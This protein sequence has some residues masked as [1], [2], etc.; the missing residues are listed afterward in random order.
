MNL[1]IAL[2]ALAIAAC[3]LSDVA[4]SA[5]FE[6]FDSVDE[7]GDVGGNDDDD[8]VDVEKSLLLSVFLFSDEFS[9][10]GDDVANVRYCI[11][12]F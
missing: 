9:E 3:I 11:Y 8:F 7:T 1:V 12:A 2:V 6:I 10:R 5:P 4:G